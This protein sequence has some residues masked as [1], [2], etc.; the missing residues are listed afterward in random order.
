[1]LGIV[2]VNDGNWFAGWVMGAGAGWVS[3]GAPYSNVGGIGTLLAV[4][5]T[6]LLI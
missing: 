6:P 1:M 4:V 5:A 2:G 3:N